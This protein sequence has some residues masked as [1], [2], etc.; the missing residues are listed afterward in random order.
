LKEEFS[1]SF[2]FSAKNLNIFWYSIIIMINDKKEDE[3][4]KDK[5]SEEPLPQIDTEKIK[6]ATAIIN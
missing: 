3:V 6:N 2:L 5:I 1:N 4:A